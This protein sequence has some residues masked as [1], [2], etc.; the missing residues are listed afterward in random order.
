M[1]F[2]FFLEWPM[3]I[4]FGR[5]HN[6]FTLVELLVVIAII[7]VLIALLL[8]AVQQARE[9]ARRITCTNKLKQLGLACHN[10][11][12][13][14]KVFPSGNIDRLTVNSS[15]PLYDSW[16]WGA[17]ILPQIEQQNLYDLMGVTQNSLNIV[18]GDA[19]PA[20]ATPASTAL[21]NG[22][23][24]ELDAYRCPSDTAGVLPSCRV[25]KYNGVAGQCPASPVRAFNTSSF[26][27]STSNYVACAGLFDAQVRK[28]NGVMY[29]QSRTGFQGMVDGTSNTL[30][31][32]ERAEYNAA[33]TWAGTSNIRGTSYSFTASTS[34]SGNSLGT[35]GT[36]LNFKN[37]TSTFYNP[38]GGFSSNHSG[39]ALFCLGDASVKFISETIQF[40]VDATSN[41]PTTSFTGDSDYSASPQMGAV[42]NLGVY[43]RLGI[44]NDGQPIGEY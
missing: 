8:P 12:D 31:I 22:M 39:G 5:R 7:G 13:S 20:T 21:K 6:G 43:Q 19:T 14:F 24:G 23:Q 38:W 26:Q 33:G 10:Y 11:A 30:L 28:N 17:L 36:P 3:S 35:V 16:G 29:A 42:L 18:I 2:A 15:S 44:R 25:I 34:D 1:F 41:T 32:G 27:A 37:Q 9:A 40:A 4:C